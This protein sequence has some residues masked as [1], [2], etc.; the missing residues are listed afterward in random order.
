MSSYPEI[1]T[2]PSGGIF[3]RSPREEREGQACKSRQRE[4]GQDSEKG[5]ARKECRIRKGVAVSGGGWCWVGRREGPE[6]KKGRC[7][8][9]GIRSLVACKG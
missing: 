9:G 4:E 2:Q 8:A 1:P 5:R 6:Y 3:W 7:R